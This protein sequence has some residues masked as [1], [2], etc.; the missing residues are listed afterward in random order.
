MG[1]LRLHF[2]E[3]GKYLDLTSLSFHDIDTLTKCVISIVPE[4]N[5]ILSNQKS[6]GKVFNLSKEEYQLYKNMV[7]NIKPTNTANREWNKI[8]FV[9]RPIEVLKEWKQILNK[10]K[11]ISKCRKYNCSKC[12]KSGH[13]KRNKIHK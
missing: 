6:Y 1:Y 7:C 5:V 3:D 4:S 13:N 10:E 8:V 9:L 12:R 2:I 11:T